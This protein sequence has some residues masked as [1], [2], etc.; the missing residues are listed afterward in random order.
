MGKVK[1]II[2][3]LWVFCIV[4]GITMMIPTD[5]KAEVSGF[6][7]YYYT[8][9]DREVVITKY[10]G[11]ESNV[12][13]PSKI[14]GKPVVEVNGFEGNKW[15]ISVTI[16]DSV[17]YIGWAAFKNCSSLTTVYGMKNVTELAD[18]AF[19]KC[20]A[21]K[22]I[23]WS[24]K[25]EKI[26]HDAFNNCNSLEAVSLT[27]I[28]EI[29]DNAFE[30]C[31]ALEEL[32]IPKGNHEYGRSL[33]KG[34]DSLKSV[35]IGSGNNITHSMFYGCTAL[36]TVVM[37]DYSYPRTIESDA[38]SGCNSLKNISLPSCLRK[39][40]AGAFENCWSLQTIQLPERLTVLGG[41][42]FRDCKSLTSV[43]VPEGITQISYSNMHGYMFLGCDNLTYITIPHSVV[44]FAG[45]Q[46]NKAR[47]VIQCYAGSAAEQFA[48]ENGYQYTLLPSVPSSGIS[49]GT[50]TIYLQKSDDYREAW[51][52]LSY[53]ISPANTT[54]AIVWESSAP[55]IVSVNSVGEIWAEDVGTAT[56]VATTTSGKRATVN[57]VVSNKPD[58]ISFSVKK[59]NV[60]KGS[61]FTLK[62]IARDSTGVRK[63]IVPHYSSSNPAIASVNEKGVVTAKAEGTA[64]IKATTSG[65]TASYKVSVF[66]RKIPSIKKVT[67][68]SRGVTVSWSSVTGADGYEIYRKTGKGKWIR[69]KKVSSQKM[70]Y[71]DPTVKDGQSYSYSVAA[72]CGTV[73]SGYSSNG[74]KIYYLSTPRLGS[75]TNRASKSMTV[76]YVRN[77]KATGYELQYS[78][79]SNFKGAKTVKVKAKSTSK[80]IK[81]LGRNQK[82][83]VRMR[84]YKKVQGTTYY[85]AWCGKKSV[86][87]R[88]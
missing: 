82:Y 51:K 87:I 18:Y 52:A 19:Y 71:T 47:T 12:T 55:R 58:S 85:S 59:K 35:V 50:K 28:K 43:K 14:A 57:V 53:T 88:K 36:E 75:A 80:K 62:A 46:S 63:D 77:T 44:D 37:E 41:G 16:P 40:G 6:W 4:A 78:M 32:I 21:L 42:A 17:K 86:T 23:P 68:N 3:I 7:E 5:A 22:T 54:D 24:G 49:L 70:S 67:N 83:Y 72:F 8:N 29:Q 38:F 48:I 34:C 39:I 64:V 60:P 27:G 74:K 20:T 76:S 56:I 31:D 79:R 84:A 15:I 81:S 30:N 13:I 25:L 65:L 45:Y 1:A 9:S 61:T 10:N 11:A 2:K 66:N 33:F 69:I 73:K 26:G